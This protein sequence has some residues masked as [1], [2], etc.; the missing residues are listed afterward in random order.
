MKLFKLSRTAVFGL[1]LAVGLFA[2]AGSQAAE[3]GVSREI[4]PVPA[5][6]FKGKIGTTYKDSVPGF[7][8]GPAGHGASGRAE[9]RAHRAR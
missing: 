9:C 1:T 2:A 8:P 4:L 7:R 6:E 5:P 3:S